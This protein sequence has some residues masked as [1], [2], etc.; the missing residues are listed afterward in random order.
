[1]TTASIVH[2]IIQTAY[3]TKEDVLDEISGILSRATEDDVCLLAFLGHGNE[4]LWQMNDGEEI[5]FRELI[6]VLRKIRSRLLIIN[7]S[8]GSHGLS[9]K[10]TRARI[11]KRRVSVIAACPSSG[12]CY[13]GL[14]RN[15]IR[16][17]KYRRKYKPE[18]AVLLDLSK[19]LRPTVEEM[20]LVYD[21]IR[22]GAALDRYFFPARKT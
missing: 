15:V 11:R 5:T 10:L 13:P 17:W 21:P 3:R 1:M 22:H 19:P 7:D 6:P 8:C 18:K 16:D 4:T 14:T 2:P 20:D 12:E 9:E